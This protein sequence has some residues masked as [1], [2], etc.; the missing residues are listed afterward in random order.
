MQFAPQTRGN[1]ALARSERTIARSNSRD[2]NSTAH[3]VSRAVARTEQPRPPSSTTR[4]NAAALAHGG[5]GGVDAV[6]RR[7]RD[8]V[9]SARAGR[10]DRSND[11]VGR[12]EWGESRSRSTQY[13]SLDRD[14]IVSVREE[15]AYARSA[16]G[17][18]GETHRDTNV[19]P[20]VSSRNPPSR[21]RAPP[22]TEWSRR[23]ANHHG[24]PDLRG[25]EV[26]AQIAYRFDGDKL[27]P[28]QRRAIA[29]RERE[30]GEQER[31]I[32]IGGGPSIS[33]NARKDVGHRARR[34]R[35]NGSETGSHFDAA[36][37]NFVAASVSS[38]SSASSGT[39]VP[40]SCS[41]SRAQRARVHDVAHSDIDAQ[42]SVYSMDSDVRR[43]LANRKCD[44]DS[45]DVDDCSETENVEASFEGHDCACGGKCN[46]SEFLSHV[47]EVDEVDRFDEPENE[48]GA[49]AYI[50]IPLAS[51]WCASIDVDHD[52]F[53]SYPEMVCYPVVYDQDIEYDD[54]YNEY[55]DE[56]GSDDP[57]YDCEPCH[58]YDDGYYEYGP[59]GDLCYNGDPQDEG[60]CYY[61]DQTGIIE[62]VENDGTQ[63]D[64]GDSGQYDQ[65]EEPSYGSEEDW[66]NS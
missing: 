57:D 19:Y 62:C 64:D 34:S 22:G 2:V 48:Y 26:D 51:D 8:F 23:D 36:R 33:A 5:N 12:P 28:R 43:A 50:Q 14:N 6:E 18:A 15:R 49:Q 7:E 32:A 40:A 55:Y 21:S 37:R 58:Q 13:A 66:D 3:R 45:D 31:A 38:W 59:D 52:G 27:S 46:C 20:R 24:Y 35:D 9:G 54:E 29:R 44:S 42:A 1:R 25:R 56:P 10:R 63:E 17:V 30:D 41:S 11:R 47:D 61:D 39:I 16:N 53:D 4:A 65:N 60:N